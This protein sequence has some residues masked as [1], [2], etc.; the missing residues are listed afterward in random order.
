MKNDDKETIELSDKIFRYDLP[1]NRRMFSYFRRKT[2]R[3]WL[4]GVWAAI[5]ETQTWE[6]GIIGPHTAKLPQGPGTFECVSSE[7][8]YLWPETKGP[9]D[10]EG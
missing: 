5:R 10:K 1:G 3:E 7:R 6:N 8:K 9:G 4:E 2:I